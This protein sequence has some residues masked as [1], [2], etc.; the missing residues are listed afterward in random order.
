M[1]FMLRQVRCVNQR[2][3][4]RERAP[5]RGSSVCK[6]LR[7]EGVWKFKE[8]EEGQCGGGTRN[9]AGE[10]GTGQTT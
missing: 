7:Q 9:K 4:G 3:G 8:L 6:F 10:G 1:T 5:G 2:D